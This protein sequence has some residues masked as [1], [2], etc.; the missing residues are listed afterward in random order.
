MIPGAYGNN[1]QC[2]SLPFLQG[3]FCFSS[4]HDIKTPYKNIVPR[5]CCF[6]NEGPKKF[7]QRPEKNAL[8]IVYFIF[9][10]CNCVA[11]YNYLNVMGLLLYLD[12]T[13]S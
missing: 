12:V 5:A 10:L 6:E 1:L 4:V 9:G 2:F 7:T 3:F 11:L 13:S 8:F